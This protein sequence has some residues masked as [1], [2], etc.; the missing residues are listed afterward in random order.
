VLPEELEVAIKVVERRRAEGAATANALRAYFNLPRLSKERRPDPLTLAQKNE[1]NARTRKGRHGRLPQPQSLGGTMLSA[2]GAKHDAAA[3]AADA[4]ALAINDEEHVLE[5]RTTSNADD[6]GDDGV[7]N[8]TDGADLSMLEADINAAAHGRS[9]MNISMVSSYSVLT[10]T[11]SDPLPERPRSQLDMFAEMEEA[12]RLATPVA[13]LIAEQN[14][15]AAEAE[16]AASGT[17]GDKKKPAKAPAKGGG[18]GKADAH[19][20]VCDESIGELHP[21]DLLPV[22]T[23]RA[24]DATLLERIAALRSRKLRLQRSIGILERELKPVKQRLSGMAAMQALGQ[25]SLNAVQPQ[26]AG[27]VEAEAE[28]QRIRMQEDE[29]F[30]SRLDQDKPA[31][32][33][34]KGKK[35]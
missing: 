34:A 12:R 24:M 27:A 10:A 8:V 28:L 29:V 17:P 20:S 21:K 5:R 19:A 6:D 1:K 26:I 4:P 16:A 18:G 23:P 30:Q 25:Y 7:I 11:K 14:R 32:V 22:P 13:E 33:N 2:G 9:A 3:E 15:L 35:K 31:S